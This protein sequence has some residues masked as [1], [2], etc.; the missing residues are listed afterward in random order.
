MKLAAAIAS[1]RG[2]RT[3]TGADLADDLQ[4]LRDQDS[5]SVSDALLCH[6]GYMSLC[7]Q[8][9]L[10]LQ[11][12]WGGSLGSASIRSFGVLPVI[13]LSNNVRLAVL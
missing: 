3:L 1:L 8:F 13:V 10:A 6:T 5:R 7:N 2:K 9:V 12:H 4:S 11:T